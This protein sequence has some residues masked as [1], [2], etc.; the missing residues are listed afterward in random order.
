MPSDSLYFTVFYVFCI[1]LVS[2]MRWIDPVRNSSSLCSAQWQLSYASYYNYVG[3]ESNSL[4]IWQ[5][6]LKT[7][8]ITLF[9]LTSV[10][11]KVQTLR[12][13]TSYFLVLK[14]FFYKF[15][16]FSHQSIKFK[17]LQ[18]FL[19][20]GILRQIFFLSLGWQKSERP[21]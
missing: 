16:Q 12:N 14:I 1:Q 7:T 17:G 18:Y 2:D 8:G 3:H 9:V 15:S 21:A 20:S 11:G 13:V 6:C 10:L 5:T 19:W 4:Q